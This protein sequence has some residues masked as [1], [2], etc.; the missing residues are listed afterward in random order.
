MPDLS[1]PADLLR[2]AATRIRETAQRADNAAPAPWTHDDVHHQ[3]LDADGATLF[4]CSCCG[5]QP[6]AAKYR[7]GYGIAGATYE[8]AHH[9]ALWSPPVAL[10]VADWLD[11]FADL[12]E[13]S[14]HRN[15]PVFGDYEQ[16]AAVARLILGGEQ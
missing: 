2:A 16:A 6:D 9:I 8:T 5:Y 4:D 3:V 1:A 13:S 7:G 10:A 12:Y 15:R 14:R 11:A